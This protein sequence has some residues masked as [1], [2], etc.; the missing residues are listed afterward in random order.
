[1]L[2]H[3][4]RAE[5]APQT[6]RRPISNP[7]SP[8]L[9]HIARHTHAHTRVGARCSVEDPCA[10]RLN[11]AGCTP[12]SVAPLCAPREVTAGIA[13]SA[14]PTWHRPTN[15]LPITMSLLHFRSDV[16]IVTANVDRVAVA[17]SLASPA[18]RATFDHRVAEMAL[19]GADIRWLPDGRDSLQSWAIAVNET[20]LDAATKLAE[21][22]LVPPYIP[23]ERCFDSS[24]Y[25][26]YREIPSVSELDKLLSMDVSQAVKDVLA[27]ARTDVLAWKSVSAEVPEHSY[28]AE[29][30]KPSAVAAHATISEA[31]RFMRNQV[32]V[33]AAPFH[34]RAAEAVAAA[35]AWRA[36]IDAA[37]R[38]CAMDLLRGEVDRFKTARAA[39]GRPV[40][41]ASGGPVLGGGGGPKVWADDVES[42]M[43]STSCTRTLSLGA[44]TR[45]RK[46]SLSGACASTCTAAS[47]GLSGTANVTRAMCGKPPTRWRTT[48]GLTRTSSLPCC[49]AVRGRRT[50]F[51]S[52]VRAGCSPAP[53]TS[54]SGRSSTGMSLT[55]ST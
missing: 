5:R 47:A 43:A 35:T 52:R 23:T 25:L 53:A 17:L 32:V 41:S 40:R 10:P 16:D 36:A 44:R 11:P 42:T 7:K 3:V 15:R 54:S 24:W 8:S 45:H 12:G 18:E 37:E 50:C 55:G 30:L 21:E 13:Y 28:K 33:N 4:R 46:G 38:A 1:M 19:R 31:L 14:P 20:N 22:K 29:K 39:A 6:K 49:S 34:A 2:A 26:R 51:A 9:V 27:A 48:R